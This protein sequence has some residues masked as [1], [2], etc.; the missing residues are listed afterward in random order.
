MIEAINNKMFEQFI[1]NFTNMMEKE[2]GDESTA[3]SPR[4]T[5]PV[6]AASL[7]GSVIVSELKKKFGKKTESE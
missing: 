2:N 6:K 4:E 5:E 7:V 3:G 1:S